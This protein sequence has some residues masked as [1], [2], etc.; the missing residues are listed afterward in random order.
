MMTP[1]I[2]ST[3]LKLSNDTLDTRE[4][5]Y[6]ISGYST[7]SDGLFTPTKCSDGLKKLANNGHNKVRLETL[8]VKGYIDSPMNGSDCRLR[9]IPFTNPALTRVICM[10]ASSHGQPEVIP[11]PH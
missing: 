5:A 7:I 1:K 9:Y 6:V 3:V 4:A 2:A 8:R 10:P 11:P